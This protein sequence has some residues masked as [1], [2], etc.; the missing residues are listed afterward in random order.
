MSLGLIGKQLR[1]PTRFRNLRFHVQP[2]A[3]LTG[4]LASLALFWSCSAVV[5]G[6]AAASPPPLQTHII[7]AATSP[8][9]GGSGA[10]NLDVHALETAT[11]G[12]GTGSFNSGNVRTTAAGELTWGAAD[13][14]NIEFR[15][16]TYGK[17]TADAS[18]VVTEYPPASSTETCNA[19]SVD[20][21]SAGSATAVANGTNE[22]AGIATFYTPAVGATPAI[23][24]KGELERIDR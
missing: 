7:S 17:G 10:T 23:L 14:F 24:K 9:E 2:A 13:P 1:K 3:L 12:G 20:A 8:V 4:M 15:G 5:K 22:C 16:S 6:S 19:D 21:T 18:G 11:T